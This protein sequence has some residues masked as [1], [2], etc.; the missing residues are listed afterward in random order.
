MFKS[1]HQRFVAPTLSLSEISKHTIRRY[2]CAKAASCMTNNTDKS[3]EAIVFDKDGT[4][5]DVQETYA[6]ILRET[7]S[8]IPGNSTRYFDVLGF[9]NASGHFDSAAPLLIDPNSRVRELLINANL[10]ADLFYQTWR[11]CESKQTL[12]E[13][14]V[15]TQRLFEKCRSFGLAVAILT[16]DDRSCTKRFLDQENVHVEALV[17][18]DDGRGYKPSAEPL[19]AIAQDLSVHP[20]SLI[21]VGDSIHDL[22]SAAAAG[23]CAVG[24]LTGAA[25]ASNLEPKADILLNSVTDINETLLSTWIKSG[26]V[27][28]T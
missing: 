4:L 7:C 17:C 26:F 1:I 10:E 24:V 25:D 23:A 8:L 11:L 18:G 22:D 15:N 14:I 16:S 2:Y 5:V 13:P 27:K 12:Y 20:S 6:H 9:D 28:K 3:F 21:M 19:F